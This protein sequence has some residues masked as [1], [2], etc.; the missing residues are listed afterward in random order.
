MH[1]N[2]VITWHLASKSEIHHSFQIRNGA[3]PATQRQVHIF[4][5]LHSS[6]HLGNVNVSLMRGEKALFEIQEVA[7]VIPTRH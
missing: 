5:W 6:A 1:R 7:D 2:A 3:E 4:M